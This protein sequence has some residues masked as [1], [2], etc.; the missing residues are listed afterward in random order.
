MK[1]FEELLPEAVFF[2]LH[3]SHIVNLTFVKKILRE[4][5]GYA[6]LED[7]AKVPVARRRKDA[8]MDVLRQQNLF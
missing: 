2:R 4:D 7:G 3:Q 6:L 5:G 1:D 8:L